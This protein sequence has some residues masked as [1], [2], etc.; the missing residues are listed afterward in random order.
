MSEPM[1]VMTRIITADSA[2]TQNDASTEKSP[3]AIQV[4]SVSSIAASRAF[5][6]S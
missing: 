4:K 2:S 3:D 5:R 6:A 1:P